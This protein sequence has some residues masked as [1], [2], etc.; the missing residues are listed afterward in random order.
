MLACPSGALLPGILF[1]AFDNK[2]LRYIDPAILLYDIR[3]RDSSRVNFKL[4]QDSIRKG[5]NLSHVWSDSALYFIDCFPCS[6]SH[7]D[8]LALL[9][10]HETPVLALVGLSVL[11]L[12][13]PKPKL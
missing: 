6:E 13:Q 10:V 4:N 2:E 9:S 5:A 3:Y 1:T 7:L 11:Q 8:F 12:Q